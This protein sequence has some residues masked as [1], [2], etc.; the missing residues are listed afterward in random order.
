MRWTAWLRRAAVTYVALLHLALL[1]QA[2]AIAWRPWATG[3]AWRPAV[4]A[5]AQATRTAHQARRASQ[6]QGAVVFLGDSIVEDMAVT[7][8]LPCA[9]NFGIGG[10]TI[11][12]VAWRAE[13]L[14]LSAAGAV[15]LH[16]GINDW[17][18]N[19][20]D[21]LPARYAALLGRIPAHVP[22]VA[23]AMLPVDPAR[24]PAFG[25]AAPAIPQANAAIRAA[26]LART[27]C[28]PVEAGADLAGQDGH[29]RPGVSVGD[30]VH[31]NP[32][33]YRLLAL[34]LRSALAAAAPALPDSACAASASPAAPPRR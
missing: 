6:L 5:E 22:V 7:G 11:D 14:D 34:R 25:G 19:R 20:F 16:A 18:A 21:G 4:Q 15:V 1:W 32:E 30:G 2:T 24:A 27:G 13:R 23:S 28:V 9:E 26:C 3:L 29:L 8:V 12:Q 10:E 33:G 31:L 17:W